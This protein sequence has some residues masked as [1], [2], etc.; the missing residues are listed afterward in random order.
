MSRTVVGRVWGKDVPSR[1]AAPTNIGRG[2]PRQNTRG[3]WSR[4]AAPRV[5]E[6]R[7]G[8]GAGWVSGSILELTCHTQES[9][10]PQG[11]GSHQKIVSRM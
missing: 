1:R 2:H 10:P 4:L 7:G 11:V 8:K 6:E 3:G 5:Q 9:G